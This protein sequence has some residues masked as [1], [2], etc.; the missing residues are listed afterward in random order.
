MALRPAFRHA[1]AQDAVH[2]PAPV[3]PPRRSP[4]SRSV[5]RS[6]RRSSLGAIS[7]V[8][9]PG[10]TTVMGVVP[11]VGMLAARDYIQHDRVVARLAHDKRVVTVRAK[12]L[13]D[14]E[15][16]RARARRP[17]DARRA[18]RRRLDR[19]HG[20]AAI[21][22]TGVLIAGANRFGADSRARAGRGAPDRAR[23]RRR[24]A[25][26]PPRRA[27]NGGAA[28]DV[29]SLVNDYRQLGAMHLSPIERLALEMAVHEE[30][31]R[32]ALEGELAD[33]RSRVARRRA[34][35]RDLRR[36]PDAAQAVR[37]ESSRALRSGLRQFVAFTNGSPH[38]SR[39]ARAPRPAARER[40]DVP[41][42][43]TSH[44]Y[45]ATDALAAHS[46]RSC[47]SSTAS[48][49]CRCAAR[50]ASPTAACADSRRTRTPSGPS[51][52]GP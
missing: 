43:P 48:R 26:C 31:E 29:M 47:M 12:H 3:S 19:V 10:I 38:A 33:A 41:A 8:A 25:S 21:H 20:T 15:L 24:A 18:A 16:Q 14:V 35:R 51:R 5:R 13:G 34:H 39:P 23:R 52:A 7:I 11:V 36:R 42:L 22:A 6:R 44:R 45:I 37:V 30:S 1:T 4:P 28:A 50:P 27:R 2:R 9:I 32:R 40:D 17:R 49:A 46:A